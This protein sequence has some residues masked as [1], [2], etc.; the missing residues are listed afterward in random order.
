[1]IL[2]GLASLNLLV[3]MRRS[4][5]K[6]VKDALSRRSLGEGGKNPVNPVQSGKSWFK[7]CRIRCTINLFLKKKNRI[8]PIEVYL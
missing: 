4:K 2:E 3:A 1:V 8:P 6:R 7:K 5:R